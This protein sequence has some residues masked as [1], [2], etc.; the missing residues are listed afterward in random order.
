VVPRIFEQAE[1]KILPDSEF[2]WLLGVMSGTAR[3]LEVQM[4]WLEGDQEKVERQ[5]LSL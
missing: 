4:T 3:H 2:T 5:D 1:P